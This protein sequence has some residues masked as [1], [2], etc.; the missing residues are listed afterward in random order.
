MSDHDEPSDVPPPN[1]DDEVLRSFVQP[2]LLEEATIHDLAF[3]FS[4]TYKDLALQSDEQFL[5]TPVT[6]LPTGDE[7]G[8]YL[9]VDVGGSNLRVGFV[10]LLGESA[11]TE[12]SAGGRERSRETIKRAQRPRVRRF[13][14]KAWPIGEHLKVD[15]AEDLFQWIGDC[16]AEV[17]RDKIEADG[18]KMEM[19]AE[20]PIG[21]TFSFP[22][23]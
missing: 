8:Q 18:A 4:K 21:V 1:Q 16:I 3:Q 2:L 12:S 9:A 22:I 15:K 14:E 13:L 19:P 10:E 20:L 23:K 7:T 5:P 6:K 17:V 11:D